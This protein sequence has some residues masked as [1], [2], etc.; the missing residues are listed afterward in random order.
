[1]QAKMN[2]EGKIVGTPTSSQ[3]LLISTVAFDTAVSLY[4]NALQNGHIT[5][6]DRLQNINRSLANAAKQ[7]LV[8]EST[9][10]LSIS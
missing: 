10:S 4:L 9:H 2:R 7:D 8:T 1:M 6:V 5:A 3:K